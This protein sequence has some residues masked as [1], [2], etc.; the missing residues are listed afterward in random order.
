VN[1]KGLILA[2]S[3]LL[4]GQLSYA[5]GDGSLTPSPAVPSTPTLVFGF[6]GGFVHHDD[7]RHPAVKFVQHLTEEYPGNVEASV[8]EN[9]R[10]REAYQIIRQR[11]D[12]NHDGALSEAEKKPARILLFGNSWGGSAVVALAERL[13]RD[14]IPVLLTIQVDS[15]AK[16]GHNDSVIPPNVHQAVNYFQTKGWVRGRRKIVAADPSRTQILGNFLLS[17]KERQVECEGFPW[18]D[19]IL[20]KTHV[21]IECDP[22]VWSD[23]E[24]MV[25]K[26]LSNSS[27]ERLDSISSVNTAGQTAPSHRE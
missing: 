21:Q 27:G 8:F 26:E 1:T 14:G 4:F 2:L 24:S 18:Y 9:R 7:A 22:K 23:I 5:A 6:L 13:N 17:Y 25:R 20:T 3:V 12:V 11:L 19:N 15:V 16:P 10:Y